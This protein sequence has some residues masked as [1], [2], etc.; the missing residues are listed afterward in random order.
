MMLT[1]PK[2][3]K[4]VATTNPHDM[5]SKSTSEPPFP[6]LICWQKNEIRF[7]SHGWEVL[8]HVEGKRVELFI[9]GVPFPRPEFGPQGHASISLRA[10]RLQCVIQYHAHQESNCRGRGEDNKEH[11]VELQ[12]TLATSPN[13]L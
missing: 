12:N 1:A 9:P 11:V 4:F 10:I 8:V 5:M 7:P 2:Q 3:Q 13:H 6:P